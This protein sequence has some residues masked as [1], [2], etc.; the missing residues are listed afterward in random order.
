MITPRDFLDGRVAPWAVLPAFP[1]N[2]T[3]QL[4]CAVAGMPGSTK[5][6][7]LLTGFAPHMTAVRKRGRNNCRSTIL[8][9]IHVTRLSAS[10]ASCKIVIKNYGQAR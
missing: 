8:F 9:P 7:L 3:V 5:N 1:L 10:E 4:Q 6:D 2:E